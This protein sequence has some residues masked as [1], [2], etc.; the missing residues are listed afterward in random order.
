MLQ[1]CNQLLDGQREIKSQISDYDLMSGVEAVE[2][3]WDTLLKGK[4]VNYSFKFIIT[5]EVHYIVV[6]IC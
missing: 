3:A 4:I 6:Q 5:I 2:E 1:K